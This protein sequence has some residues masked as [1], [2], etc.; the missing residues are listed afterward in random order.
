MRTTY[1][2]KLI[3]SHWTSEPGHQD[4]SLHLLPSSPH[5]LLCEQEDWIPSGLITVGV[6]ASTG[7]HRFDQPEHKVGNLKLLLP[8]EGSDVVKDPEHLPVLML[9]GLDSPSS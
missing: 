8:S 7:L 9:R 1:L 2:G 6:L 4:S 5:L 3:G